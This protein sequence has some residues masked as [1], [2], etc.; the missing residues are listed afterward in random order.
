MNRK[1][2]WL[3]PV[4]DEILRNNLATA[5]QIYKIF[6]NKMQ[7]QPCRTSI[8]PVTAALFVAKEVGQG[9]GV[10]P[11]QEGPT[12]PS[13]ERHPGEGNVEAMQVV[14]GRDL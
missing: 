11:N 5:M 9:G 13:S 8:I 2:E 1:D 12:L 4:R 14:G 3:K 10:C 7:I 6:F